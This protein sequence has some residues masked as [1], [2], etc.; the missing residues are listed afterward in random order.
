LRFSEN[1]LD[2][3]V[4]V[5]CTLAM[6]AHRNKQVG[7]LQGG[8]NEAVAVRGAVDRVVEDISPKVVVRV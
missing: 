3:K 2:A 7:R 6:R 4:L 8:G 5:R 1:D